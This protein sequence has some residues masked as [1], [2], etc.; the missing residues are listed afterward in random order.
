[1]S[2]TIRLPAGEKEKKE[3]KYTLYVSGNITY[4]KKDA[5]NGTLITV[6]GTAVAFYF[7]SNSRRAIV[8]QEL[9]EKDYMENGLHS[10]EGK[11]PYIHNL[12]R[13]IYRIPG[14]HRMDYLKMM[15]YNLENEYGKLIY[16]LPQPYW[17]HILSFIDAWKPEKNT[18]GKCSN[19]RQLFMI[20]DSYLE[21][22]GIVREEKGKNESNKRPA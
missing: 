1:M 21:R 7:A 15:L 3:D 2:V 4:L 17:L 18:K 6:E 22:Y 20:T 8:F 5:G 11:L 14:T 9:S 12:V 10:E 13:I 16:S 19:K